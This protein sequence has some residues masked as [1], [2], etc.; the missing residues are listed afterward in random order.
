MSKPRTLDTLGKFQTLLGIS[1]LVPSSSRHWILWCKYFH[2]IQFSA[3]TSFFAEV[4][5]EFDEFVSLIG[6]FVLH[7]ARA[8]NKLT[9]MTFTFS[10]YANS[11][12]SV[13]SPSIVVRSDGGFVFYLFRVTPKKIKP[14]IQWK[15]STVCGTLSG[16]TRLHSH[17]LR[18]FITVREKFHQFKL[19]QYIWNLMKIK[20]PQYNLRYCINCRILI[21]FV[22][23]AAHDVT[24]HCSF[25]A[26]TYFTEP[27]HESLCVNNCRCFVLMWRVVFLMHGRALDTMTLMMIGVV[28]PVRWGSIQITRI[29]LSQSAVVLA[30]LRNKFSKIMKMR[31]ISRT[32]YLPDCFVECACLDDAMALKL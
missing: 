27:Y 13:M 22:R 15:C 17:W 32:F 18:S 1:H 14:A 24:P 3:N 7:G 5:D 19:L 4:G 25:G 31:I 6:A 30:K 11:K 9:E 10:R 2:K 23:R 29:S 28:V 20:C 8:N 12:A 16:F 21:S 26:T